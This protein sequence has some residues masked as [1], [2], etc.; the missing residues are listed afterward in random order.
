M[1]RPI[2]SF[3]AEADARRG[4]AHLRSLMARDSNRL[5]P[6]Q[7]VLAEELMDRVYKS[8]INGKHYAVADYLKE[9]A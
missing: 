1:R 9:Q 7:W 6:G 4:A 8:Q 2:E 5:S 3:D